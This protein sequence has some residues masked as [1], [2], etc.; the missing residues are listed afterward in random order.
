MLENYKSIKTSPS[1][2]CIHPQVFCNDIADTITKEV[3]SM[4]YLAG[5][6]CTRTSKRIGGPLSPDLYFHS[7]STSQEFFLYT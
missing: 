4:G 7:G 6:V 5:P 1:G 3:G 2:A